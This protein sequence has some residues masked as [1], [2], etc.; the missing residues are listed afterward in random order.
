MIKLKVVKEGDAETVNDGELV[1]RLINNDRQAAEVIVNRHLKKVYGLLWSLTRNETVAEDLTQATFARLWQ[2]PEK[3]DSKRG[4]LCTWLYRV[5]HNLWIDEVRRH[6]RVDVVDMTASENETLVST[7]DDDNERKVMNSHLHQAVQQLSPSQR[8]A[9]E[10][11]YFKRLSYAEAAEIMGI[12]VRALGA[13]LVRGRCR[14]RE[15]LG[16]EL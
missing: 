8:C 15:M 4:S 3:Y 11:C 6:R 5:G 2:K 7:R 13:L 1:R 10:L 14:L 12:S 16:A 9:V